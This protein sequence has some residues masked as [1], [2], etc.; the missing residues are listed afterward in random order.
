MLKP[1]VKFAVLTVACFAATAGVYPFGTKSQSNELQKLRLELRKPMP[2]ENEVAARDQLAKLQAQAAVQI[3][4][5]GESATVWSLLRHTP[6]PS[7]RTYLIHDFAAMNVDPRLLISRLRVE[8]DASVRRALIL[9]LGEFNDEQLPANQRR[10]LVVMLLRWYPEDSDPGIHAAIGWLLRSAKQG[11]ASRKMDWGQAAALSAIDESLA[12]RRAESRR[13][14]VTR[15][16]QTIVTLR[17][18]M[19]FRMGSPSYELGR[20]PATDSP[21]EPLHRTNIPRSFAISSTEVTIGQFQ[22][23]LDDNPAVKD[24]F[25]Y[26]D[27]PNRMA[28]VLRTFS[29]DRDGPQ[30]AVTWYEAAMY[31][32]WLSQREGIP[33]SEWVYPKNFEHIADGMTMPKDYLHRTGYRLPTEAEW[34]YAARAGATTSRFFGN[35]EAMLRE[36]GWYSRNPPRRKGDPADPNDPQRTWPVGQ[37]KP[38]DFGLFDIYGNV[39]EWCQD[40]MRSYQANDLTIVDREDAISL[41]TDRVA[42]SR[43]GGA[44]PYEAAM[45]RSAGRDTI[46]AFPMLRRDNVGFRV[47]RTYR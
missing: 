12:G 27:D 5:L 34:E 29:P 43:R 31:C 36:Y 44:F 30:I 10:P 38:N 46:N 20:V 15:Q 45:Q 33:E 40:R 47:A 7:R 3:L 11:D 6:D 17:G 19:Q 32:N 1:V 8:K 28:R 23:F 42:R 25:V 14:Y 16:G 26:G 24:R 22:R 4:L 13:W 9:S 2:A 21:D 37:L 41:I 18:P 35:S 39:W